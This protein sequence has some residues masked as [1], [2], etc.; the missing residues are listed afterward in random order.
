M[1]IIGR[2]KIYAPTQKPESK[3]SNKTKQNRLKIGLLGLVLS[4]LNVRPTIYKSLQYIVEL[5]ICSYVVGPLSAP[6]IKL[7]PNSIVLQERGG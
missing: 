4:K 3:K 6:V 7:G 1:F 2:V 5:L